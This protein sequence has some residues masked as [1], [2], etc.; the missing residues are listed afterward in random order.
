MVKPRNAEIVVLRQGHISLEALSVDPIAAAAN[1]W[2]ADGGACAS[3][4]VG[5]RHVF[6]PQLLHQWI[7]TDSPRVE[8]IQVVLH[9]TRDQNAVAH[10]HARNRALDGDEVRPA[11]ALIIPKQV[12]LAAEYLFGNHWPAEGGA[13]AAVVISRNGSAAKIVVPGVGVPI[14]VEVVLVH[15]AV[16]GVGSALGHDLHLC[17]GG[18]IEVGGLVG[19]IDFEFFHAV[20]RSRHHAGRSAHAGKLAGDAAGGVSAKARRV[21]IHA[22]VHVV[23]VVA[24]VELEAGLIDHC[25]GHA[26]VRTDAGLQGHEGAHIASQT[27]KRFQG[28]TGHGV[29]YSGVHGLKFGAGG[30]NRHFLR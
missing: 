17:A 5:Q 26:A 29:S 21:H 11:E 1:E 23:G 28:D 18:V 22:A 7:D 19:G 14:V 6:V 24:A 15:G 13:K 3:R 9:T 20:S 4:V 8:R 12:G 16:D 30:F 25:A 10:V 2:T 27:G